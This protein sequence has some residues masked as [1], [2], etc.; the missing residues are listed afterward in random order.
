[1]DELIDCEAIAAQ[2]RRRGKSGASAWTYAMQR[3]TASEPAVGTCSLDWR[4]PRWRSNSPPT[5]NS[6]ALRG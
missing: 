2:A 5:P 6:V 4:Q 3:S 1:M